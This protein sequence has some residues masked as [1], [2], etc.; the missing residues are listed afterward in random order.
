MDF[1]AMDC[2][3]SERTYCIEDG[4]IVGLEIIFGFAWERPFASMTDCLA[5]AHEKD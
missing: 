1:E 3:G 5:W 2:I 4:N